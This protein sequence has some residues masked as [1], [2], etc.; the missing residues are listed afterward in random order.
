[1]IK[2]GD[3]LVVVRCKYFPKLRG[4]VGKA[5]RK[6]LYNGKIFYELHAVNT[7]PN[8]LVDMDKKAW[9]KGDRTCRGED[10]IELISHHEIIK[11]SPTL[12]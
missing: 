2:K 5:T 9:K 3:I 8:P 7:D 1:M 4:L 11:R 6:M 10:E 12:I